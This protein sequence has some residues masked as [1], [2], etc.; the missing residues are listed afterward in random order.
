LFGAFSSRD[1]YPLKSDLG[2]TG[3]RSLLAKIPSSS[4]DRKLRRPGSDVRRKSFRALQASAFH[5][6]VEI[7][8]V[9]ADCHF[10]PNVAI[11]N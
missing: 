6:R 2:I 3:L 11:E 5:E 10:F 9:P 8:A 7:P 1:W 4:R